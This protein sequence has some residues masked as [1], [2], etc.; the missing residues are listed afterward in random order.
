[1]RHSSPALR[2]GAGAMSPRAA[3]R[4]RPRF[5]AM[6]L[7]CLTASLGLYATSPLAALWSV[8]TAMQRD[9]V[10]T[11][12]GALAWRDVRGGLKDDLG[13]G[14]SVTLASAHAAPV[15]DELPD[16]GSSF[17]TTIVSHVVDDVVT[18][19]HLVTMLSQANTGRAVAATSLARR[20]L[21]MLGRVQH[22]GFVG[23][24][25][26]EASIRLVDDPSAGPMIVSMHVEK[27]QWKITRI[28]LPDDLLTHSGART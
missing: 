11:V 24:T 19:E 2:T 23:P 21:A 16:F 8:S 9:D 3:R 22:V 13:P 27:W 4:R 25:G 10:N 1:M 12:R 7:G 28:H 26:F 17:A 5:F 20:A 15:Q 6:T 14:A 18:P